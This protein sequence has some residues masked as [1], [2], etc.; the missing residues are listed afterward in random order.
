MKYSYLILLLFLSSCNSYKISKTVSSTD[1]TAEEQPYYEEF[2][3][4]AAGTVTGVTL[5]FPTSIIEGH[6]LIAVYFQ[7]LENNRAKFTS[8]NKQMLVSRFN[9]PGTRDNSSLDPKDE[10]GNEPPKLEKLPFELLNNEAVIAYD[11]DGKIK[12]TKLQNI[13]QKESIAY[14]SVPQQQK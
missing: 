8:V 2:T 5:Y 7:G 1:F 12:Y 14:P 3:G 6:Q 11:V 13:T 10:Y 4:G 9:F